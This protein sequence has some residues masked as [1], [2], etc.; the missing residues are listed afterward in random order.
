MISRLNLCEI[1]ASLSQVE[2]QWASLDA[3]L[4]QSGVG[5]KEPFT[6]SLRT[7]MLSAYAYLDDM[8]ARDVLP[9]SPDGLDQMLALNERVH[10]GEDSALRQEF[11]GAIASNADKFDRQ[12]EPISEWY[13][14]HAGR[15]EHPYK[16]AAETY[17]SIVGQP[18]LFIEGNNRTG[19]LIASWINLCRRLPTVRALRSERG[20]VLRAVRGNQTIR[21]P[22][23]VARP[24]P[25]A[26][27]SQVV[28]H[29]L[30]KPRR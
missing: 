22:F 15:G 18:Q 13:W 6:T 3:T 10:Y 12:I 25:V 4:Q 27:V 19:S 26:Q 7:K 11:A 21:R 14:K 24:P 16:L 28:S 17:V 2:L 5:H 23:D 1:D 8:L 9:F 30:G 20:R 29:L